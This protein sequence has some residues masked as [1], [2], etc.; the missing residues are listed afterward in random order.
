MPKHSPGP[1]TLEQKRNDIQIKS[2]D[3][4]SVTAFSL[5][6][7]YV[8]AELEMANA[9]LVVRAPELLEGLKQA[10]AQMEADYQLT[11][12][13]GRGALIRKLKHIVAKTEE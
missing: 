11:P 12:L 10:V 2:A 13:D 5:D 8:P 6:G 1:W 3:G 4:L 7:D 9:K